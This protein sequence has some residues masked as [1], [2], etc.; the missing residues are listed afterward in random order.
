MGTC[1]HLSACHQHSQ[2]QSIGYIIQTDKNMKEERLSVL[3]PITRDLHSN[4]TTSMQVIAIK[5]DTISSFVKFLFP[6]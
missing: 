1:L 6:Q 4:A 3:S 2:I 5:M